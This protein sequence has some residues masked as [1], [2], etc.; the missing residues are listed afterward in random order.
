M[1]LLGASC[2]K[3]REEKYGVFIASKRDSV[4]K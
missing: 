1:R 4:E 2:E 3:A